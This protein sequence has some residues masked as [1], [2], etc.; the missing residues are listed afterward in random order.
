MIK[1]SII[2]PT[3]DRHYLLQH[4]LRACLATNRDDIEVIVSDNFSGP[5]TKS[6]VDAHLQDGRLRYF[7]TDRRMPMPE[8]WD[9]AW[10]KARGRFVIIN[11]DDDLLPASGINAIDRAIEQLDP[12]VITWHIALYFHPDYDLEGPANTVLFPAGHSNLNVLLD[13]RA[14]IA[15]YA[16]FNYRYFPESTHFCLRK[17]LGDKIINTTGRLFWAPAPDFSAPLLALAA[18]ENGQYCYIDSMLGFGG[19]SA[20]SNAAGLVRTSSSENAKRV[21]EFVS[22]FDGEDNLFP[23][24][25]LKIP[26]FYNTHLA[27]VSLLKKFYPQFADLKVDTSWLFRSIYEELFEIRH[28]PMIDISMEKPL[29]DYIKSLDPDQRSV[30]ES[31]RSEVLHR[32]NQRIPRDFN[33]FVRR[34]TPESLKDG[35]KRLLIRSKL[36]TKTASLERIAGADQ[37]FGDG[38]DLGTNWDRIVGKY[39]FFSLA[40]IHEAVSK[41]LVLSAHSIREPQG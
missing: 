29:N 24:H 20:H 23:H 7:R 13:P 26:F 2:I 40:N 28:N 39:D 8:H 35:I 1:F 32:R 12:Q 18:I 41:G 38:F 15:E 16:K 9:F 11:C 10:A 37:G 25:P 6:V 30:A 3:A 17:D 19:R 5:E 33:E 22:E 27:A 14:V 21:K 31:A 34:V 4:S 36:Y